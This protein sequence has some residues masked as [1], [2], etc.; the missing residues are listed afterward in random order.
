MKEFK[1][2]NTTETYD[3]NRS[4]LLNGGELQINCFEHTDG[5]KDVSL[6]SQQV[7]SSIKIPPVSVTLPSGV[8]VLNQAAQ[9]LGNKVE[10]SITKCIEANKTLLKVIRAKTVISIITQIIWCLHKRLGNV[11]M[12]PNARPLAGW[13]VGR[14]F[15]IS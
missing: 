2:T 12:T 4:R 5:Q 1:V 6:S 10:M 8:Q 11:T 9:C 14:S 13:L 7:K 15:L 3:N